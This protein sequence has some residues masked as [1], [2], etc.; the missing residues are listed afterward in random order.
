MLSYFIIRYLTVLVGMV[1]VLD[2][3]VSELRISWYAVTATRCIPAQEYPVE[4]KAFILSYYLYQACLEC[5]LFFF[6][7]SIKQGPKGV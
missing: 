3:L 5:R 4:R 2:P 1:V 6:F 7:F